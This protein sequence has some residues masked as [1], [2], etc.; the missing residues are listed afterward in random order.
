MSRPALRKENVVGWSHH[1]LLPLTVVATAI[2]VK[3]VAVI[4]RKKQE[5]NQRSRR[6]LAFS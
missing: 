6:V 2:R 3:I 5:R 4:H 1:L